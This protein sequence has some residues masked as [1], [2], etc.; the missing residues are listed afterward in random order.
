MP[1]TTIAPIQVQKFLKGIS[2]PANRNELINRAKQNKADGEVISI[3]E[4]LK[5]DTFKNPAEVSK[6]IGKID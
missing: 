2:Y 3:L 5:D 6:A 4:K 1:R